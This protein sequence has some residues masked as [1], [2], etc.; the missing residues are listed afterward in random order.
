MEK[1][2]KFQIVSCSGASNT[3]LFAD[4]VARQLN[5][6]NEASMICLAKVAI[7]DQTLINK[8]KS[9]QNK[10]VVLDG[11]AV[12]CAQKLLAREGITE[13][14]HINTTDFG[15]VK[16]QTPFSEAKAKEIADH[17]IKITQ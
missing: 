12:N 17:I 10:I 2:A 16:G 1:Q 4:A 6:D 8:V 14:I 15:I 11:C 5:D 7:G 9:Q 13:I 3:G